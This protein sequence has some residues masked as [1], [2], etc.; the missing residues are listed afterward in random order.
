MKNVPE[1]ESEKKKNQS[2]SVTPTGQ[3]LFKAIAEK[4]GCPA[5]TLLEDIARGRQVLIPRQYL[6]ESKEHL[7]LKGLA[8]NYYLIENKPE[9]SEECE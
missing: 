1:I 8:L 6:E 3:E 2:F 7:A 5:S 4:V 9:E